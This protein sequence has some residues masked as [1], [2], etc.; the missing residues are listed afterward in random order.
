M[1]IAKLIA[2]LLVA[3]LLAGC[4]DPE[5]EQMKAR[6]A[7]LAQRLQ[8]IEQGKIERIA[9]EQARV[10]MLE[11]R[12]LTWPLSGLLPVPPAAPVVEGLRLQPDFRAY[13]LV[14]T[15]WVGVA[16][17]LAAAGAAGWLVARRSW[18]AQDVEQVKLD[19]AAVK[20]QLEMA[21]EA[22]AS[23]AAEQARLEEL[24]RK[25]AAL[26][27]R[28]EELEREIESEK[29]A[30]LAAYRKQLED[31]KARQLR[32]ALDEGLKDL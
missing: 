25:V 3:A 17:V 21:R 12:R 29:A 6:L 18:L 14:A 7:V 5:T 9:E 4:A 32:A 16:A 15:V 30:A 8:E 26:E 22:R 13:A 31:E 20:S 1:A 10:N 19:L 23:L 27:K 11:A 24:R 28:R 2:K